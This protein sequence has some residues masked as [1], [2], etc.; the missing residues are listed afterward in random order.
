MSQKESGVSNKV[1]LK[2]KTRRREA[3]LL[4][5]KIQWFGFF[6]LSLRKLAQNRGGKGVKSPAD[7][8]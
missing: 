6:C 5:K 3:E 7:S 4:E 8:L 2:Y 1:D